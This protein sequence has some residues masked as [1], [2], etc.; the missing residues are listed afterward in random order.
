MK[1]VWLLLALCAIVVSAVAIQQQA[2]NEKIGARLRR[3][4]SAHENAPLHNLPKRSRIP[5]QQ[6]NVADTT[7]IWV[8]FTDKC[9]T[10]ADLPHLTEAAIARRAKHGHALPLASPFLFLPFSTNSYSI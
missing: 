10:A 8:F 2:W 3:F 4:L 6:G 1:K 5:D 9:S 7:G